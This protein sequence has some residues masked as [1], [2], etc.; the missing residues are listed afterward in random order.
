MQKSKSIFVPDYPLDGMCSDNTSFE[1]YT[2]A[3]S[4]VFSLVP[5]GDFVVDTPS[6]TKAMNVANINDEEGLKSAIASYNN[7]ENIFIR[8][9]DDI[10]VT[11]SIEI[12]GTGDLVIDGCEHRMSFIETQYA[13]KSYIGDAAVCP[14][15][16]TVDGR[17][18][19]VTPDG[20]IIRL[21]Q[22][23]FYNA[24]GGIVKSSN[25]P[26]PLTSD[27]EAQYSFL[28]PN[29]LRNLNILQDENVFVNFTVS[30]KSYT[31]KTWTAA[32]EKENYLYFQAKLGK[33]NNDY[34]DYHRP[35]SFFFIN[36]D[37]SQNACLVK[38]S[39]LYFPSQYEWVGELKGGFTIR[40]GN[41]KFKNLQL[42]GSAP[43]KVEDEACVVL[44]KCTIY[45]ATEK[46]AIE[47]TLH[48]K[49]YISQCKVYN[50][51]GNGIL[52]RYGSTIYVTDS[53]FYD[54]GLFRGQTEAIKSRGKYYIAQNKIED[55]CYGAIRVGIIDIDTAED[56]VS[57]KADKEKVK[58]NPFPCCGIVE[59]NDI[60]LSPAFYNNADHLVGIDGGAIYIATNNGSVKESMDT[61]TF[62]SKNIGCTLD[63]TNVCV[64]RF[65]HIKNY[66]GRGTNRGIYCDDDAYNFLLLGN[67]IENTPND[68]SISARFAE[69]N[70]KTFYF[71][72]DYNKKVFYNVV[73]NGFRFEGNMKPA[74]IGGDL[75][76][77]EDFDGCEM[78]YNLYL[79]KY[80][81]LSNIIRY[82]TRDDNVYID[83]SGFFTEDGRIDS[84]YNIKE[85]KINIKNRRHERR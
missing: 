80:G 51:L 42:T 82:T 15:K 8:L 41:I 21:S 66:R 62:I 3:S 72:K 71:K 9:T 19:F 56:D 43:M 39:N 23:D 58:D 26:S 18:S 69:A 75:I 49:A 48:A 32:N 6:F 13:P 14:Y 85:W 30:Y 2:K 60:S 29:E 52:A 16:G 47:I 63:D 38:D 33:Y 10:V 40:S 83:D 12:N 57:H 68:H 46:N 17:N 53:H 34:A 79:N 20:T 74:I 35:T 5:E 27:E 11:T 76:N 45:G 44:H 28:L 24:A 78:K 36:K 31:F 54:I 37:Q 59:Y 1:D 81:N 61:E 73:D 50:C 70:R 25:S 64:V 7:G 22:S 65:N 84:A 77:T 67:I 55:F 4:S